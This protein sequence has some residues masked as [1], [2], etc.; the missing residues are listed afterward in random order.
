MQ[1]KSRSNSLTLKRFGKSQAFEHE[2]ADVRHS[3]Q[4]INRDIVDTSEKKKRPRD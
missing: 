2:H 3:R 4:V 1:N